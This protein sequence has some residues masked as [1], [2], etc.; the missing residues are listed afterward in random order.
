M[1]SFGR[2]GGDLEGLEPMS[3]APDST[4][5]LRKDIC[6]RGLFEESERGPEVRP[7]T[8]RPLSSE[9]PWRLRV[10]RLEFEQA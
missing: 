5:S 1:V 4:R 10:I 9:V 6:R 3:F 8:C 2:S 7:A